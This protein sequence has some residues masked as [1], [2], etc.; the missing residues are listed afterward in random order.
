M[1]TE[2]LIQSYYKSLNQKDDNWQELYSDDAFFADA[3]QT[4]V[5]KG[6][7]AVIQAFVP[8]LKG[9]AGLKISQMI[10]EDEKACFIISYTY[11]N[12]KN[13]RLVQD[14]A[15]VWEVSNGKLAKQIIYFDLTAYR[16]FMQG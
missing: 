7:E 14:V 10:V 2:E 8:F 1:T 6:K 11:V 3:S 13:E 9:V 12:R 4:L 15:E 16:R 5:A